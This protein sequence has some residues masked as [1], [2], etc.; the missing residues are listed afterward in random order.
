MGASG[1]SMDAQRLIDR[2]PNILTNFTGGQSLDH[3]AFIKLSGDWDKTPDLVARDVVCASF[4]SRH[5][6]DRGNDE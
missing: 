4:S 6:N 2:Q 3:V 5:E 1:I